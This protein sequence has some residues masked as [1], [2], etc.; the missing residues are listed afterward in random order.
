MAFQLSPGVNV[1]EIDLTNVVPAVSSS[2]GAFAGQFSWGPANKRILVDS[3]NNLVAIFGKPT[4]DNFTSFFSVSSFLAY[5]NNIRVVRAIDNVN[6]V[7]ATAISEYLG[8]ALTA[9]TIA[10]SKNITFSAN[11]QNYLIAGETFTV[12]SST[13]I[14]NTITGNLVVVSANAAVTANVVSATLPITET[15]VSI[16]NEDDYEINYSLGSRTKFGSFYARYV[17]DL[18]NSLSVSVCSSSDANTGWGTWA[19]KSYFDSA[20]GTSLK[21]KG[22]ND[23][24]HIIVID[25]D[26]KFTGEK[27]TIL[28]KYAHVSKA[29]DNITDDG[30]PNYYV[31]VIFNQSNYIYVAKH[32]STST[33]WGQGSTNI[34]FDSPINYSVKLSGGVN[35]PPQTSDIVTSYGLFG[36]PDE[37]DISLIITGAAN[38]TIA[39][40]AVTLATQ[41]KD[42]VAFISPL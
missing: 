30:S 39:D 17:G 7:N 11:V 26:G 10:L 12:G 14:A 35:A 38:L 34:T 23:E 33:N 15:S 19:Y 21:S 13:Y 9:N 32:L 25:T 22:T 27:G 1:S 18:G 16:N 3:E 6:T 20:P 2:I 37:V 28:E 42:C 5:T 31:T 36:N 29:S 24:M 41:R 8:T 4:D 40:Q